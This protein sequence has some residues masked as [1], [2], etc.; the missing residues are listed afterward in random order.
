MTT[1]DANLTVNANVTLAIDP[2]T[3]RERSMRELE[4]AIPGDFA[5][6]VYRGW[7]PVIR[8]HLTPQQLVEYELYL[9]CVVCGLIAGQCDCR[10]R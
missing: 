6:I 5:A 10:A 8:N 4:A 9:P 7:W 2:E 3:G 1:L